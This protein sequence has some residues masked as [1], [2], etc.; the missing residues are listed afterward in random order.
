MC[1]EVGLDFC[2]RS[3]QVITGLRSRLLSTM[4]LG[5]THDDDDGLL[6][7]IQ[8]FVKI[9]CERQ[10][11]FGSPRDKKGMTDAASTQDPNARYARKAGNGR[12]TC[13]K[14]PPLSYEKGERKCY[15]CNHYGHMAR[16]CPQRK[17]ALRSL[18]CNKTVP[19]PTSLQR[20]GTSKA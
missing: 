5:K 14:P 6:H 19:H 4:L 13:D 7:Y 8:E 15:N 11:H 12:N 10:E 1:K 18:H 9:E 3:K 16:D 2:D 17:R 20:G